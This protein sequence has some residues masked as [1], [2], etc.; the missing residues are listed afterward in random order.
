[1]IIEASLIEVLK[2]TGDKQFHIMIIVIDQINFS[3]I[4]SVFFFAIDVNK[5]VSFS[6]LILLNEQF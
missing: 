1:M 6:D 3:I 2:I 5:H 4:V